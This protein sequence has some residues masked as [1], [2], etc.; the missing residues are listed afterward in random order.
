[1]EISVEQAIKSL[2]FVSYSEGL[3][4]SSYGIAYTVFGNGRGLYVLTEYITTNLLYT[5]TFADQN[6]YNICDD[7]VDIEDE[8]LAVIVS[9]R[10]YDYIVQQ[11]EIL[12]GYTLFWYDL[13]STEGVSDLPEWIERV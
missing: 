11:I 10:N 13:K 8:K 4:G 1:M 5:A 9:I 6:Q 2:P 3:F 12:T 7:C